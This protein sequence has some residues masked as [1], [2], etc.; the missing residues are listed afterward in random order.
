MDW[1]DILLTQ[2]TER[3]RHAKISGFV[4]TPCV[5]LCLDGSYPYRRSVPGN[6]DTAH[7]SECDCE[8]CNTDLLFFS[9][10]RKRLSPNMR[11]GLNHSAWDVHPRAER[12]NAGRV[13]A[14]N[15]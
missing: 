10:R 1:L 3:E 4:P 6:W 13:P 5:V 7:S 8:R 9:Y 11:S 14:S 15:S 2:Q 12:N